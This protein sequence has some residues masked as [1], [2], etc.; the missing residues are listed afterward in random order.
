[1]NSESMRWF[2]LAL[3]AFALWLVRPLHTEYAKSV[4]YRENAGGVG[5]S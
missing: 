2:V 4:L 5:E 3:N 1:M